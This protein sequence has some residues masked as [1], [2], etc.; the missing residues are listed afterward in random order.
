MGGVE[1]E[2]H[3]VPPEQQQQHQHQRG[4]HQRLLHIPRRNSQNIAEQDVG[5]VDVAARLRHEHKAQR[6][7]AGEHKPDDGVFLHP[8]LLFD[9][10]DRGN[11]AHT[12]NER[13]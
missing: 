13:P 10:A 8:R 7:E 2:Q 6:E 11:G 12:E 9:E 1:A 3:Q 4:N 5:E